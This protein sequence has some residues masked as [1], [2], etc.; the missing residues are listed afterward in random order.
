MKI[1]KRQNKILAFL[2]A[3]Q[4]EVTIDELSEMLHVSPVTIR[5]DLH[6]LEK[7]KAIIRT[8][9]GCMNAGRMAMETEYHKKV[10]L[11]FD[12][13]QSIGKR[14]AGE[15]AEGD[16]ILVDDGST[17]FHIAAHLGHFKSLSV[18]TNSFALIPELKRF[19]GISLSILG[20]EVDADRYSVSG[21]LTEDVIERIRFDK[22]FLGVDAIDASGRCFVKSESLA[23]LARIMLRNGREKILLSDHTKVGLEEHFSYGT[24]DD[25][26]K[27]ITTRGIGKKQME[28]FNKL[29]K[30]IL[31]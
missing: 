11:N 5:R 29:T 13:K 23:R 12:L 31:S 30:V 19:P 15:V 6:E 22:V 20:G 9:G 8:H 26:D 4:R 7:E 3:M 16:V 2:R 24:L 28:V 21:Y 17:T 10:A 14:A 27:W 1:Q 25:F 18:Y